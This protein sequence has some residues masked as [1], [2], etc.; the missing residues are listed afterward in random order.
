MFIV[1]QLALMRMENTANNA[2]KKIA[3]NAGNV[4]RVY[5]I[6]KSL[7]MKECRKILL[8]IFYL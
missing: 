6:R 5:A 2:F 4:Y 1:W 7:F 3:V 8:N